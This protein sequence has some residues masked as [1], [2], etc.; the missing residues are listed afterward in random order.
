MNLFSDLTSKNN[1]KVNKY[2]VKGK[3]IIIDT[4]NGKYALKKDNN[5]RLFKYLESKNYHHFPKVIDYTRESS[6]YEYIEDIKYDEEER[7]LDL[8]RTLALLHNKTSFYKEVTEFEIKELYED[9]LSKINY[10]TNYYIDLINVIESKIY[11]SPSEYLLARNISKVFSATYYCKNE[12]EKFLTENKDIKRKRVV[13]L[14][15]NVDTTNLLRNEH[16]YLISWNNSSVD[17]P[18]YDIINFYDKRCLDFDFEFLL[19][20]Y[21]KINP[22]KKEEKTLLFILISLPYKVEF[23][24]NEYQNTKNIRKFLDKIYKT[25]YILKFEKE[26][27]SANTKENEH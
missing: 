7:A 9:I 21:E 20:E 16:S 19:T 27:K 17:M 25:E 13:T 2:T 6:M 3:S 18:I 1:L 11:M 5:I 10:I 24:T 22:L 23:T 8:I 14:H 26:K 12:L 4:D 15:N